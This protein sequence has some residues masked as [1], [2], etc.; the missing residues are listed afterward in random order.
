M[1]TIPVQTSQSSPSYAPVSAHVQLTLTAHARFPELWTNQDNANSLNSTID[2]LR[3]Q[4]AEQQVARRLS[5]SCCSQHTQALVASQATELQ[6]L[7]EVS[8]LRLVEWELPPNIF[9]CIYLP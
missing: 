3:A 6:R 8:S 1:M 4:L 7:L 2:C 5:R 9:L